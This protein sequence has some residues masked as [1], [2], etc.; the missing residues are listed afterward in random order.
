MLKDE[1]TNEE[2]YP[3]KDD[4]PK[5]VADKVSTAACLFDSHVLD[6]SRILCLVHTAEAE[7]YFRV[8]VL[9]EL[10]DLQTPGQLI[11]LL[12]LSRRSR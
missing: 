12:R 4:E 2:R 11:T 6:L 8:F 9:T 3:T 5:D 10:E 1:L 7:K